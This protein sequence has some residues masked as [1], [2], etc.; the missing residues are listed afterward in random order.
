MLG[1]RNQKSTKKRTRCFSKTG[2]AFNFNPQYPTAGSDGDNDGGDD[3]AV[4]GCSTFPLSTG[5]VITINSAAQQRVVFCALGNA[6]YRQIN[7]W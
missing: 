6:G 3:G 5:R 1:K 4:N 2:E 7:T